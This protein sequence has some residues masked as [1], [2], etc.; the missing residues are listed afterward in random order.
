MLC[1][2]LQTTQDFNSDNF[3]YKI[4]KL[5]LQITDWLSAI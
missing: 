5:S 4:I 2:C 3:R 1:R